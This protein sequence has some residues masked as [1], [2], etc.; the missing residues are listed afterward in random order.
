VLSGKKNRVGG[1]CVNITVL[2]A[3]T[4]IYIYIY[5]HSRK[6]RAHMR[7][8]KTGGAAFK[9]VCGMNVHRTF[10][11]HHKCMYVDYTINIHVLHI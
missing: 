5:T 8:K 4:F 9:I 2:I 3:V 6:Q 11:T 1:Q 10:I 7:T